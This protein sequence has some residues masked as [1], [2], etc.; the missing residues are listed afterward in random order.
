MGINHFE[1]LSVDQI[2]SVMDLRWS[3]REKLDGSYFE[4]GLD[5]EGKFYS[6]RKGCA[7][8]FNVKDWPESPW[9]LSYRH[10]HIIV[11]DFIDVL[12]DLGHIVPGDCFKSEIIFAHSQPNTIHYNGLKL[13][14]GAIVITSHPS[15][16]HEKKN[17]CLYFTSRFNGEVVSSCDGVSVST[18][19]IPMK[20]I[21]DSV[22]PTGHMYVHSKLHRHAEVL[23]KELEGIL[24]GPGVISGFS[25]RDV[26]DVKLNTRPSIVEKTDWAE[27]KILLKAEREHLRGLILEK[28]LAFKDLMYRALVLDTSSCFGAGS[29]KEGVVVEADNGIIFKVTKRDEFSKA[30]LFSHL[31]KYWLVGGRRPSR[32]CFVS[33]TKDWPVEKRL[34][35][36]D[37]LRRRFIANK[38]K[39]TRD[40]DLG[41]TSHFMR[42]SYAN[43]DLM[44]RTLL[45]F[46]DLRERILNGR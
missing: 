44:N 29:F 40:F 5:P 27:K 14:F 36:L 15:E 26:L 7:P 21:V 35:R 39:L 18:K 28:V 2:L 16:Y 4:F 30:N 1:D 19:K 23:R 31:V 24:S 11:N 9:A 10:A 41:T 3:V 43:V 42:I 37:V 17:K 33:R 8:C 25:N 38:S 13:N 6:K 32:P 12:K 45:L 20:W 34:E 46:A 22:I